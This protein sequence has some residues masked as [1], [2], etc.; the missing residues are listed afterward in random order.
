M[1]RTDSANHQ[2]N[3]IGAITIHALGVP[4][5]GPQGC[6]SSFAF[7]LRRCVQNAAVGAAPIEYSRTLPSVATG[8]SRYLACAE[9]VAARLLRGV[10]SGG[11]SA[12]PVA[13]DHRATH[14]RHVGQRR[15]NR[16]LP[17]NPILAI[18]GPGE[19]GSLGREHLAED[20]RPASS[21]C[22]VP[23]RSPVRCVFVLA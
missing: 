23:R 22:G 13:A 12:G 18:A 5:C 11:L 20:L 3:T 7:A 17:P 4:L 6:D 2:R 9:I 1:P 16:L 15:R 10:R 14:A 21:A 8:E 19:G